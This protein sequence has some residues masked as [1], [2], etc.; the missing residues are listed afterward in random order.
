M[1]YLTDKSRI[2][3]TIRNRKKGISAQDLAD[4]LNISNKNSVYA[5]IASLRREGHRIPGVVGRD[6][7]LRYSYTT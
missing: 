4:K 6:G 1:K 7:L 2:L 3:N 5:A